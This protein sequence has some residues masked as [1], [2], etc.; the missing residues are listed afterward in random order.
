MDALLDRL[1]ADM[2]GLKRD[3]LKIA[4]SAFQTY[5]YRGGQMKI[6]YKPTGGVSTLKLDGPRG[7]RQFEIY[8]HPWTLSDSSGDGR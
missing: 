5:P 3:A 7:Q 2:T 8:F 6:D 4:I 1:P